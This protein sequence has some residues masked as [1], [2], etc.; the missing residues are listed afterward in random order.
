[1]L[2]IFLGFVTN[3]LLKINA[4]LSVAL[5]LPPV[6]YFAS[7]LPLIGL[8]KQKKSVL[9]LNSFITFILVWLTV[10]ILFYNI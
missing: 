1:M 10:W 5:G 8:V 7:L 9:F 2:G 4:D 3:Y 6:V